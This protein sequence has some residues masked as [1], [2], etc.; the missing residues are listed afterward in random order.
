M[1]GRVYTVVR[2]AT[3]KQIENKVQDR[4]FYKKNTQLIFI[5]S[6]RKWRNL[7]TGILVEHAILWGSVIWKRLQGAFRMHTAGLLENAVP[8]LT[9]SVSAAGSDA[10]PVSP[11]SSSWTTRYISCDERPRRTLGGAA[12]PSVTGSSSRSPAPAAN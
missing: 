4:T 11:R 5:I 1:V 12:G 2:Y 3:L 6:C 8:R 9:Y 10:V 7:S